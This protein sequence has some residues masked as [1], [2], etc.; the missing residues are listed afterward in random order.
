MNA[1]GERGIEGA[2]IA[3]ITAQIIQALVTF[4]Y[5]RHK[6]DVIKIKKICIEKSIYKAMFSVGVSAMLMQILALVQQSFL[7]SQAFRYGG[8]GMA[9]IMSASLKIQA[10][11]FIPLWGMSQGLQPAIGA[12]YGAKQFDR[13]RLIFKYFSIGATILSA[14]FWIPGEVL[15]KPI[16]A[17]FGLSPA[18]LSLGIP[19]F[20][21]MYSIFITYG[22]MIMMMTFFQAIGDGKNAGLMVMMRQ[23][24]LFIPA[25]LLFPLFMGAMGIWLVLPIVDGLVVILGLIMYRRCI[26]KLDIKK[27]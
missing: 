15:T 7:Y 6:S 25:V 8:D 10:F 3:T 11:S 12:N 14:C 16:L 4:Y 21:I 13:M 9:A 22:L 19:S 20:R 2:A 24:I 5:F 26:G 23:V 18:S 27:S 17:M 1:M